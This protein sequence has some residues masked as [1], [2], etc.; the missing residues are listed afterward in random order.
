MSEKALDY[1]MIYDFSCGMIE[2][3][4]DIYFCSVLLF[5]G[6]NCFALAL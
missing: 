6:K 4:L 3:G 1:S 2:F 5:T